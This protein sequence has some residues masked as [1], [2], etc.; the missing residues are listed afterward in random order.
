MDEVLRFQPPLRKRVGHLVCGVAVMAVIGY[1]ATRAFQ[2]GGVGSV[3]AWIQLALVAMVLWVTVNSLRLGIT[4]EGRTARVVSDIWA[5][6]LNAGEID[7]FEVRKWLGQ[8]SLSI[9]LR[10]GKR[11]V[12]NHF[13]SWRRPAS[14]LDRLVE[15]LE[16]WRQGT[17]QS[18]R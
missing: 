7:R 1:F 5:W 18:P 6:K 8:W 16:S 3:E 4:V 10:S 2:G 15:Q 17:R 11:L 12:Q 13:S 14:D 9:D